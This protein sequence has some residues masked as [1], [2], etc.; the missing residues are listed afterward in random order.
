MGPIAF[1]G[2]LA[3]VYSEYSFCKIRFLTQQ[4]YNSEAGNIDRPSQCRLNQRQ[5]NPGPT[6]NDRQGQCQIIDTS[7]T[8][9]FPAAAPPAAACFFDR[10]V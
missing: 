7:L 1:L 5:H 2:S 9:T 4:R 6:G 8:R 10:Q 3:Q